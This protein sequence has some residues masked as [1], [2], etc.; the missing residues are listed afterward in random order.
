MKN[1]LLHETWVRVAGR[2]EESVVDG[3]GLR[4]VLFTQG[5]PHNCPGCHNPETHAFGGG[6]RVR[7]DNILACILKNPLIRK[8]TFSGGEPFIQAAELLPLAR[9]LRERHFHLLAYTGYTFEELLQSPEHCTFL[10]TLDMLVDGPFIQ[11]RHS[12]NLPFRGSD[13]QRILD[14]PASLAAG[15]ACIHAVHTC[16]A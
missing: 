14:V 1:S 11:A 13:N 7:L 9:E 5:C 4:F 15:K 6:V 3:P 8:V 10:E 12:L 2:A 16:G